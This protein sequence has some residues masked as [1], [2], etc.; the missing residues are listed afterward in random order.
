M[1]SMKT[2]P[3]LVN[4]FIYNS[5]FGPKEG[6]EKEKIVMYIPTGEDLDKKIKNIGLCEALVKFTQTFSP[7][8]PCNSLHTQKMRQVFFE[9][10]PEFWMIMT[11]SIPFSEKMA[12][13]GKM[14]IEYHDEDVLDSVLDAVLKQ[15]YKMFKLFNGTFGYI[16]KTY[17]LEALRKRAEH[18]YASYL[19]T[20]NFSQF[21]ILDAFTG[22]NFLP[23]DKNTFLRIQS[24]VNVIEHT[25]SQ[26]KYTAFLYSEKLVWSGLEQED[27]RTLYKYLVSSLFPSTINL[28]S[29]ENPRSQGY[30]VVQPKLHQG[31]FI[32]GPSDLGDVP[33][34]STPP[35]MFV[36]TDSE[37]E[38]LILVVYKALEATICLMI[39]DPYPSLELYK[40]IDTFIGPQLTTLANIVGEQSAKKQLATDQQ[41][42]YLYFNHMN[43]AQK[44]SVHSRKS[45]LPCVAPEIMRLMGDISIDFASFQEDGE[46]YVKTMSDCWIVGRKSDQREIFVILNQKNANLIEIDEEVRRL[47]ITQFNNIFFLD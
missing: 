2:S 47:G 3:G 35:K 20:F 39:S 22:I 7:N 16:L 11:V 43:L 44:S 19:Q 30:V 1:A 34:P 4:F 41:Y 29:M 14:V 42:R 10:E 15:A 26:I 36:N 5:T 9:A 23:L 24:F 12:K 33:V 18:F 31:R 37:Q 38:E 45:S 28:E 8:K 40:R 6:M 21:D 32:T 17:H 13:D 25:F 27:M 46:T